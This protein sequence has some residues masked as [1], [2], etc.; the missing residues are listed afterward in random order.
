MEYAAGLA[1]AF[2]LK[3]DPAQARDVLLPLVESKDA[4]FDFFNT[5]GQAVR[6]SGDIKGAVKWFGRALTF[7][8]PAVEALNA[9][10]ECYLKLGDKEQALQSFKKSLE[11]TPN[12]PRIKDLVKEIN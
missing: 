3:K 1:R 5:L 6:D 2:L 11:I 12:Q 9:L 7:R 4:K 8:G 10:G